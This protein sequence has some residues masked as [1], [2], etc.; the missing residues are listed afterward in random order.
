MLLS[1]GEPPLAPAARVE[2]EDLL[3]RGLQIRRAVFGDQHTETAASY[4]LLG[5]FQLYH[6]KDYEKI[7]EAYS[8]ESFKRDLE[9][10]LQD[11]VLREPTEMLCALIQNGKLDI[12]IAL[13]R[14]EIYH[15]KKGYF[16]DDFGNIVAFDGSGNETLSALKPFDR[17]NA[18]SFNFLRY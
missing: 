12:H 13:L 3:M 16:E 5:N 1:H 7:L 4:H 14:G 18:E 6:E 2:A 10:L 11:P 8:E 9:E 15:H 17:G